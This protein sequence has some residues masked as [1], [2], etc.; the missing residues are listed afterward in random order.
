[1]SLNDW[2]EKG[3]TKEVYIDRLDKHK[4]A[5]H[6]I[7]NT[8]NVPNEDV[9]SLENVKDI[10]ALILAAEWCG[11]CMLDIAVFL[12]IANKANIPTRFLIRDDNLE[13][14]DRYL[15]NEK[16]YI[17]IMIFIDE[18]GNEVGKWGPWAPEINDFTNRLKEDL[19]E[20]DSDEFDEAFQ[21]YIKK[22]GAA[23]ESD[24]AL[25]HYVYQDIKQTVV[26]I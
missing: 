14:M 20:R 11:H 12:H 26:S 15:T 1:M 13:L 23:F 7:M 18:N 6:L 25:W 3:L 9:A 22:V 21:Q 17:P 8:F 10:R 16:R 4:E 24:T 19:P 5:F 2:Y